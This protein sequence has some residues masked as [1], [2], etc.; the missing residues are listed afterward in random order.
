[1]IRFHLVTLAFFFALPSFQSV[2]SQPTTN[3]VLDQLNIATNSGAISY[4]V[5]ARGP[6]HKVIQYSTLETNAFGN[7]A[8]VRTNTHFYTELGTGMHRK[9]LRG[10]WIE[11]SDEIAPTT[12]GAAATNTAH[13]VMFTANANSEQA[14]R[15]ILP[16]GRVLAGHVFCL[17]YF[18]PATGSNVIIA[19]LTNSI[20]QLLEPN[21]VIYTNALSGD[22]SADI[23]YE[24]RLAGIEQN[25]ILRSRPRDYGLSSPILQIWTEF[26][27]VPA[28]SVFSEDTNSF[29]SDQQIDF[30]CMKMRPGKG[31]SIGEGISEDS[32]APVIKQW[33]EISNRVFLVEQIQVDSI[34]SQ[35]QMLPSGSAGGMGNG[36]VGPHGS[37]RSRLS[38]HRYADSGSKKAMQLA[39]FDPM[40]Q[41]GFL[42]DFD[43]TGAITNVTFQSD[44]TYYISS[45]VDLAGSNNVFEGGTVIKLA[46]DASVVISPTT[47]SPNVFFRGAPYR[48]IVFTAKDDQSI[49]ASIS[50]SAPTP[51]GYYANPALFFESISQTPALDHVRVVYAKKAIALS[52]ASLTATNC[53]FVNC[54]KAVEGSGSTTRFRNVLF[55]NTGSNFIAT[56]FMT[57]SC[58]NGTFSGSACLAAAPS[59]ST[60]TTVSLTNCV[61]ANVP[62]LTNGTLTLKGSYNGFWSAYPF[63]SST[64]VSSSNPLQTAGAGSAYLAFGSIFVN[65]GTTNIHPSLLAVLPKLTT[66]PPI[67]VSNVLIS[68]D[69]VLAPQAQR[70]T[71]MPDLGYHYDPLD[72]AFHTVQVTNATLQIKPGTALSMAGLAS[73]YGLAP[74]ARGKIICQG[75]P[76]TLVQIARYNMVQEPGNTN[77]NPI[78]RSVLANGWTD[79]PAPELRFSFTDW[80][81]PAQDADQFESFY[82][83]STFSFAN[84]QFH[85]GKFDVQVP[86]FS[87]T[88]CLFERVNVVIT[89]DATGANIS[90]IVR[91]CLFFGGQLNLT[92]YS[93]DTWL[94]RD[95]AFDHAAITQDGDVDESYVGYIN[96]SNR[97]TPTN[98]HDVV[99]SLSWQS[100]VLG[101]YY[102]PTNSAFINFGSTY[103]SS[104]GLYHYTVTTNFV[105]GIQMKETNSVVDLGFHYV[106]LNSLAQPMDADGD[107][108]ADYL[109]DTNG[110]GSLTSG[111]TNWQSSENGTTGTP[112]LQ[113]FTVLE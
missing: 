13:Q 85:G 34:T 104:L 79:T 68:T 60:G 25:I 17:S 113:I 1:M 98:S 44:T 65:A 39:Q 4:T 8:M 48:P 74:K 78:C 84:S 66:Y 19:E 53:Q 16:D 87:V 57:V 100:N 64:I 96:G 22:C 49:G 71:D 12:A 51:S 109:E 30:G 62:T 67:V 33:I 112:G 10:E 77:W 110:D 9:N 47:T 80:A 86:A 105:S 14:L 11:A 95:D 81:M 73:T 54:Q 21:R 56:G 69:T 72:Y 92:H 41:P 82:N 106:A 23:L 35:L 70:D 24:N 111:E 2:K 108:I 99:T 61:L 107:N 93:S 38:E 7:Q 18:E 101:N 20:G 97:L 75:S 102:Q 31:L 55:A 27:T 26:V 52:S 43:L 6:H 50:G 42:A 45:E 91:N 15:V 83:S 37:I 89:D 76:A 29:L 32:L 58:E 103:A 59:S 3:T 36:A 40:R 63:G 46:S 90:P 28:L 88:N 5:L 94:F